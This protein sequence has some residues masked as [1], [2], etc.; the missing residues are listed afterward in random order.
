MDVAE[1]LAAQQPAEPQGPDREWLD[2][3]ENELLAAAPAP[4]DDGITKRESIVDFWLEQ[5]ANTEAEIK[6]NR[7]VAGNRR[8]MIDRATEMIETQPQRFVETP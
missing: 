5:L 6:R 8:A 3:V 2:F 1:Q 7:M 4:A